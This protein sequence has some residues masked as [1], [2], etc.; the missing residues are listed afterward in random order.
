MAGYASVLRP[1]GTSNLDERYVSHLVLRAE[2]HGVPRITLAH[3]A[4]VHPLVSPCQLVRLVN[5]DVAPRA[6][7]CVVVEA[8]HRRRGVVAERTIHHGPTSNPT[9]TAP[10]TA[11]RRAEHASSGL[12]SKTTARDLSK[13]LTANAPLF[14]APPSN[15]APFNR[16][17][18]PAHFPRCAVDSCVDSR[19]SEE[20]RVAV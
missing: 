17:D 9:R 18:A 12:Y 16:T 1:P 19:A 5:L 4:Q 11:R 10:K 20:G 6:Q 14:A 13:S 8:E 2:H 3:L 15:P 7:L